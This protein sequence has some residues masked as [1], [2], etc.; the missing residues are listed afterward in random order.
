MDKVGK[1]TKKNVEKESKNKKNPNIAA[2][3]IFHY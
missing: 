3:I 1:K 2:W